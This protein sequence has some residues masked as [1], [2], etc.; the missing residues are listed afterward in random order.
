LR[1][2]SGGQQSHFKTQQYPAFLS[3]L[4]KPDQHSADV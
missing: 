3:V 1:A 2:L 4:L